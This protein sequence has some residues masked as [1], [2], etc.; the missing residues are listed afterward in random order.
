MADEEAQLEP[1]LSKRPRS[2]MPARIRTSPIGV[3][4]RLAIRISYEDENS[5]EE[6][7]LSKWD[8]GCDSESVSETEEQYSMG[9][10]NAADSDEETESEASTP[11]SKI[12]TF[13]T[14]YPCIYQR[15]SRLPR[16][17]APDLALG[18]PDA[19]VSWQFLDGIGD[20][21]VKL[22]VQHCSREVS[23]A[24]YAS[25]G[26]AVVESKCDV[27]VWLCLQRLDQ[28]DPNHLTISLADWLLKPT[29]SLAIVCS[30]MAGLPNPD[31]HGDGIKILRRCPSVKLQ[32]RLWRLW[33]LAKDAKDEFWVKT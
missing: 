27:I 18:V 11:K 6:F 12:L 30:Q 24:Y 10:E 21:P 2:T 8:E 9:S 4:L 29:L 7:A 5:S 31:M 1:Y 32:V 25:G 14:I 13:G 23:L 16:Q 3:E 22:Q 20:M 28:T 15:A 33:R 26:S 17:F 19:E